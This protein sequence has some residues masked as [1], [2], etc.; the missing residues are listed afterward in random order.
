MNI[1]SILRKAAEIERLSHEIASEFKSLKL[2]DDVA[3]AKTKVK[4]YSIPAD[5][6][7]QEYENLY[8][9]F[10]KGNRAAIETYVVSKHK[11]YLKQFCRANSLSVDRSKDSK[12]K[13][14]EVVLQSM[15]LRKAITKESWLVSKN[16]PATKT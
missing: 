15:V 8:K 5:E 14:A 2:R 6:L 7:K 13:I 9:E 10:E 4:A 3:K 12:K 16:T 11:D 1:E